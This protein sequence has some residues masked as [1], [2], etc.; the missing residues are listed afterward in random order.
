M[1][2]CLLF[3]C[4]MNDSIRYQLPLYC[5]NLVEMW[6]K[7]LP[8]TPRFSVSSQDDSN[9]VGC[10]GSSSEDDSNIVFAWVLDLVP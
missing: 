6:L 9:I 7:R 5:H 2:I 1:K 4:S 10:C 3:A 8:M